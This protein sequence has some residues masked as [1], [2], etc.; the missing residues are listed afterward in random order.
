[1]RVVVIGLGLFGTS[2]AET[3]AESG[4]EV[5]AIDRDENLVQQVVDRGVLTHAACVDATRKAHLERLGVGEDY[6]VGVIG[7]GTNMEASIVASIHLK[8]LGV[9]R[10]IAKALN[11]THEKILLKVGADETLIPEV[12]SGSE[13][14]RSILYPSV[15]EEIE[16]V[17]GFHILEFRAPAVITG[18]SLSESGLRQEF[19]ANVIGYKRGATVSFVVTPDHV[20]EPEDILIVGVAKTDRKKLLDLAESKA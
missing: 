3:I 8:E 11:E 1:M 9:Q 2:V 17:E 14:A 18:K 12:S 16:F 13:A 19:G 20:I 6:S 5:L 10:V 4:E 7:I 15:L